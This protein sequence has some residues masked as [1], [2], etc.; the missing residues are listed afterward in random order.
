MV[1]CSLCS[2]QESFLRPL[3]TWCIPMVLFSCS[4]EKQLSLLHTGKRNRISA[5]QLSLALSPLHWQTAKEKARVRASHSVC[6]PRQFILFAR[7]DR[8]DQFSE[9]ARAI[10]LTLSWSSCYQDISAAVV[11][12][13]VCVFR[14]NLVQQTTILVWFSVASLGVIFFLQDL[15]DTKLN[16]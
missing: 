12:P 2:K 3:A 11:S 14:F 16:P 6:R 4:A 15:T 8:K 13:C 1:I 10:I 9:A 5:P 7:Y